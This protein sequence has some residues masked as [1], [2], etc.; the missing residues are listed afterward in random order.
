MTDR[1]GKPIV[2]DDGKRWSRGIPANCTP[3]QIAA[4]M[5]KELRIKFRSGERASGF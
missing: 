3:Q 2:D 5:A 1:E 4:R